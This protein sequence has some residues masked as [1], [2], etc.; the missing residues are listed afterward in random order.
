VKNL[1]KFVAANQ[2]GATDAKLGAKARA[3]TK[4]AENASASVKAYWGKD[5]YAHGKAADAHLKAARANLSAGNHEKAN[6][7][8]AAAN[9]HTAIAGGQ[10]RDSHGRF[11]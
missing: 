3:A 5:P 9:E 10:P 7:H 8:I 11:A 6:E 4:V 2:N 1:G